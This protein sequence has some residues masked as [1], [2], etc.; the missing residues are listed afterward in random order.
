MRTTRR[1]FLLSS[2]A[3]AASMA[4]PTSLL[5][6]T[7]AP[8]HGGVLNVHLGS[9]QR[10]LNPA[11][12]ASTGVYIVTSKIIESLV[13]LDAAGQPASP[14]MTASPLRRPTCNTTRWSSGRNT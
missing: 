3:L 12:R 14:G 6:Q 9:E 10:I 5:A 7:T 11:L 8:R 2:G 1:E 13:D 4:F